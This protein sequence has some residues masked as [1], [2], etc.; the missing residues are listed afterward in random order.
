MTWPIVSPPFLAG[1]LAARNNRI[2]KSKESRGKSLFEACLGTF[3]PPVIA[4]VLGM[5]FMWVFSGFVP[6]LNK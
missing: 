4:L 5:G 1:L 3:L 6:K 2:A